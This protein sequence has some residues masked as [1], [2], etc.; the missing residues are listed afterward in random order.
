MVKNLP[1]KAGDLGSIPGP[2]R[3][4]ILWGSKP[5]HLNYSAHEP[6]LQKPAC[7]S[8]LSRAPKQMWPQ[9]REAHALQLEKAHMQ[10]QRLSAD[11][12]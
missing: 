10:Q 9:Q 4:H 12:K 3:S 8:T 5:M 1:A 11:Q 6:Q 7:P 2:G